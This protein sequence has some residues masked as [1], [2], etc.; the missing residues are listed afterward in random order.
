MCGINRESVYDRIKRGR[1]KTSPLCEKPMIDL[2]EYPPSKYK[3]K[4]IELSKSE[5]P[6]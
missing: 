6:F 5:I 2:N 3:H 4:P 1:L